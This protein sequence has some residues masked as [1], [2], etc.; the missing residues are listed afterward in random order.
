MRKDAVEVIK[1]LMRNGVMATINQVIDYDTAAT[2]VS[3]FGYKPDPL[4]EA[5][6]VTTRSAEPLLE[7]DDPS[8]L[9]PRS[10]VVTVLGHVDHGKTTLLDAIR[11]TNVVDSEVGGITQHIGAYQVKY[12]G[13]EITFIDT[14]GHEAFTAM[15]ARGA[16][17]TDIAVLV[18]AADDGLMPQTLEA[19]DHAKAAVV[20]IVVAINKVD[21]PDSDVER[22]K[23]QLA[24]Q[25]LLIEEWGGDIIAVPISAKERQGV[26]DL[27]E[28]ILV[29]AEI[30]DLKANPD[31]SAVGIV[32]EASVDRGKGPVA[33]V[34]IQTGTLRVGDRVVVGDTRGRVKALINEMGSRVKQAGPSTPVE[35]VG[36]GELPAAGDLLMV[37]PD[38]KTA[39]ELVEE[40]IRKRALEKG[41]GGGPTLEEVFSS[42]EAGEVKELS[43]VIKTDVQG[44]VDAVRSS[45]ENL[46][47]D[48]AKV[49]MVR[50]ATG[51][52][53]ENDV[54]LAV[55][56]KAIIIGFNSRPEPSA[57]RLAEQEEVD[58]RFYDI[59]YKL[60]E[61]VEKALQGLLEPSTQEVVEGHGEVRTVFS[62][63]RRS[64][65]A[66]VYVTDGKI[67]R[68]SLMRV[69]RD[70]EVV[71]DGRVG[72]LKHFKDD[73]R[74]MAVGYECGLGI[75]GFTDVKEGDFLEAYAVR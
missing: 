55:A 26:E 46:A 40:R 59:I 2:V 7:E 41:T 73:V 42:I 63:G 25:N 68:N 1:Q 24:E 48:T 19:I 18:V 28:N 56:S 62:L 14:P 33:S 23:R 69:I 32:I 16:Q 22:V 10:P 70:G 15:R 67:S 31:R 51:N 12:D 53:T 11:Q 5:S 57:S 35:V 39:R 72:S 27:L 8:H 20:P 36:L 38:E 37:V 21:K 50:V 47:T 17:V 49:K 65:I 30:S 44:S 58:I 74:E 6:K 13:R 52:I 66:G 61:D 71:F 29:V 60:M 64:K 9:E 34:L 45:L 54:L 4:A 75:E 3:D 43:L